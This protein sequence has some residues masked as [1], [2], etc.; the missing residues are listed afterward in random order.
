M[1]GSALVG[2]FANGTPLP[3]GCVI[4][5]AGIGSLVS[6]LLAGRSRRGEALSV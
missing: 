2:L 3:M 1:I 5:L 6:A 4:A